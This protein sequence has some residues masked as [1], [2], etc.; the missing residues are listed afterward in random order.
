MVDLIK[1]A[2]LIFHHG[3]RDSNILPISL[4]PA[5]HLRPSLESDQCSWRAQVQHFASTVSSF[6]CAY[7]YLQSLIEVSGA[8]NTKLSSANFKTPDTFL[9]QSNIVRAGVRLLDS[10]NYGNQDYDGMEGMK[11]S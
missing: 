10:G 11:T 4:M 7:Q 9:Q 8:G 2:H 6:R 3:V 5:L 1:S